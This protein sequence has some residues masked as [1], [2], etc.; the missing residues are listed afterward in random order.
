MSTD[1]PSTSNT[2]ITT[3][4]VAAASPVDAVVKKP[5]KPRVSQLGP[6]IGGDVS[7]ARPKRACKGVEKMGMVKTVKTVRKKKAV[8]G[9]SSTDVGSVKTKVSPETAKKLA[10]APSS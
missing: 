7:A 10:A 9:T 3:P 8:D 1:A 4:A 2:E 5:R 6:I